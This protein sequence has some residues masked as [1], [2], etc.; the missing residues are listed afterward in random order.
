M[1]WWVNQWNN[2]SSM[3]RALALL[4]LSMFVFGA[5]GIN[6]AAT[7]YFFE[8][9]SSSTLLYAFV[10]MM[11]AHKAYNLRFITVL[12]FAFCVG[13]GVEIVGVKT[14]AI[15]GKYEYTSLLGFHLLSVPIIIGINW[16]SLTYTT[17]NIAAY[18]IKNKAFASIFAAMAMVGFDMLIEP[19]AIKHK[20]WIWLDD[21][22]PPI[23][24]YISWFIVSLILSFTYQSLIDTKLNFMTVIFSI[25][26]I[27]F[28]LID[29]LI[30]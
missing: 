22:S 7:K 24:N 21:G 10:V 14:G 16:I 19:L 27:F 17:N 5:V 11:I 13:M 3:E 28:L 23:Q 1:N 8:P 2:L 9:L 20:F 30:K 6:L 15:F 12:V 26:L 25:G 29:I 18:L 4:L